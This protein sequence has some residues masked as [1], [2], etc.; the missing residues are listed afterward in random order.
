MSKKELRDFSAIMQ[1]E[2]IRPQMQ[3]L[4]RVIE[5]LMKNKSSWLGLD[6]ERMWE[7]LYPNHDPSYNSSSMRR[8]M[9]ELLQHLLRYLSQ[10]YLEHDPL[11]KA[12][13]VS[14][15]YTDR[16]LDGLAQKA[17]RKWIE[18]DNPKSAKELLAKHAFRMSE[19]WD[20]SN[21][22][23][24]LRHNDVLQLLDLENYFIVESLEVLI[25]VMSNSLIH[26]APGAKITFSFLDPVVHI[27]GQIPYSDQ[28]LIAT[29]R[30]F[31][32]VLAKITEGDL[33]S[34]STL[35]P[36]L[37]QTLLH[38]QNK[39]DRESRVYLWHR[40][41]SVC[42]YFINVGNSDQQLQFTHEL[43]ELYRRSIKAGEMDEKGRLPGEHLKNMIAI[44]VRLDRPE[45]GTK[46][47]E[48]FIDKVATHERQL[49]YQ[50][51]RGV[52]AYCYGQLEYALEL[53]DSVKSSNPL[54]NFWA[55]FFKIKVQWEN[56]EV[57]GQYPQDALDSCHATIAYLQ[58]QNFFRAPRKQ[59]Y[60][61]RLRLFRKVLTAIGSRQ[62]LTKCRN[63]INS[64]TNASDR[65][66]LFKRIEHA[67]KSL[68]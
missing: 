68:V 51:N 64:K 11:L 47:L 29:Y 55:R 15:I 52:L 2:N 65:D 62:H 40:L 59:Q 33:S 46:Y 57:H 27:S 14:R 13:I 43:L 8:L 1:G 60:L 16:G 49:V 19:Y 41:K 44:T 66:Y 4:F 53:L 28:P 45:L 6:Y 7:R 30:K 22:N 34:A 24:K 38:H 31:Y 9:A 61:I 21:T 42:V 3:S 39:I 18:N 58:R 37:K 25:E 12:Q 36:Q 23:P 26:Q 10:V 48:Q 67:L 56:A 5:E 35:Y 32:L 20:N 50:Y 63:Q 54:W 17:R